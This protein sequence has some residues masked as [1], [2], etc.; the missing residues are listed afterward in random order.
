MGIN[1]AVVPRAIRERCGGEASPTRQKHPK[2][3][4][5][6]NGEFSVG[7][8]YKTEEEVKDDE[9]WAWIRPSEELKN[10]APSNLVSGV[11]L[12]QRPRYGLKGVTGY[13]RKMV[14]NGAWMLQRR[15]GRKNLGFATFTIPDV[16]ESAMIRIHDRWGEVVRQL[17][18]Y[19][20]RAAKKAMVRPWYAMV[21]EIS[22]RR[23]QD[24]GK[25]VLHIHVV[26]QSRT[27]G[28]GW[29]LDAS[30]IRNFWTRLLAR[31]GGV[32]FDGLARV[33]LEVVRKS[34]EGYIGKYMSKSGAAIAEIVDNGDGEMLP[35]QWWSMSKE[36]KE[37]VKRG[38]AKGFAVGGRLLD[39]VNMALGVTENET[40]E[41]LFF[42]PILLFLDGRQLLFGYIGRLKT[43][44]SL[45]AV[46]GSVQEYRVEA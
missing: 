45:G 40:K 3:M 20:V 17:G 21:T 32:S 16:D 5:W 37:A 35:R 24:T 36:L 44:E 28:G 2:G 11:K 27:P 26:F 41:S 12:S 4:V 19:I 25:V 14:R 42:R 13:G 23:L 9:E 7:W 38:T 30:G 31:V 6:P 46:V 15:S 43:E 18:Q 10:E 22:P 34:A 8:A 33:K 29:V 1:G 39:V